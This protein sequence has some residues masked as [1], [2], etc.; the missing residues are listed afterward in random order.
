MLKVLDEKKA[1]I[2]FAVTGR[3]AEENPEL[4]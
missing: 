4:Y 1:K 3:W 2:T